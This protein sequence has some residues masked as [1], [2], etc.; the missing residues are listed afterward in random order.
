MGLHE[1]VTIR[2]GYLL[3]LTIATVTGWALFAIS[4]LA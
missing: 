1:L 3:L 2:R 4:L